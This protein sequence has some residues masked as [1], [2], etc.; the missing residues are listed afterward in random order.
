M[1]KKKKVS[2]ETKKR[3]S[4]SLKGELNHF[5]NKKHSIEALNKIRVSKSLN[6]IFVYDYFNHLL[7][8]FPSIFTLAKTVKANFNSIKNLMESGLLFLF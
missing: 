6:E 4:E 3:I 8:I 2:E 7:V 1:S 5:Y